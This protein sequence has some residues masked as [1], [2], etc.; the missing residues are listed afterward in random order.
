[1]F[2]QMSG[3]GSKV[4]LTLNSS[5]RFLGYRAFYNND[6]QLVFRFNNPPGGV[7]G[8]TI[9]VDPGHGGTD[10]GALGFLPITPKRSLP[11]RSPR[12]WRT[13]WRAWAPM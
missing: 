5:G 11:G 2:S 6:G 4:T 8:A 10:V 13:S 9:V 7:N 12:R 1:M 3:S